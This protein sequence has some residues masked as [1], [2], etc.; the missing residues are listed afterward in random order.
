LRRLVKTNPG[1]QQEYWLAEIERA[2]EMSMESAWKILSAALR[3]QQDSVRA[4]ARDAIVRFGRQPGAEEAVKELLERALAQEP[5]ESA[6]ARELAQARAKLESGTF[7]FMRRKRKTEP[8]KPAS[9]PAKPAHGLAAKL[10]SPNA[11]ERLNAVWAFVAQAKKDSARGM[12][13][14]AAGVLLNHAA[15]E[16][17]PLVLVEIQSAL[18]TLQRA[19]LAPASMSIPTL[20]PSACLGAGTEMDLYLTRGL[21]H[22][23]R[24]D[25]EALPKFE[26]KLKVLKLMGQ[27]KRGFE[28]ALLACSAPAPEPYQS[29][30]H[31]LAKNHGELPD[32]DKQL[33]TAMH[34]VCTKREM[35]GLQRA[36]L[37]LPEP[38]RSDILVRVNRLE[39]LFPDG[40][41]LERQPSRSDLPKADVPQVRL[42]WFE[43]ARMPE[44]QIVSLLFLP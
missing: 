16:T 11:A 13:S 21:K 10:Q 6:C 2:A 38:E 7:A 15:A 43:S 18:V 26:A 4:A 25:V 44:G 1:V 22:I 5:P 20:P 32:A 39:S 24:L 3:Q 23:S 33:L 35:L 29:V 8:T 36:R 17:S 42:L 40:K 19:R 9:A 37:F 27:W 31:R 30:I 12:P 41:I 28:E 34:A 14:D